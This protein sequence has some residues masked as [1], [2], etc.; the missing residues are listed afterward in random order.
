MS[1]FG[2]AMRDEFRVF[3]ILLLELLESGEVDR[4]VAKLREIL[5]K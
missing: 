5:D 1:V 3:I 4:A 2:T